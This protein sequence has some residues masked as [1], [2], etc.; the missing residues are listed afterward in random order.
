MKSGIES[1]TS[2]DCSAAATFA[3]PANHPFNMPRG[4]RT[5]DVGSFVVSNC[6]RDGITPFS[7]LSPSP[8]DSR[9]PRLTSDRTVR[10]T[11]LRSEAQSQ[12]TVTPC[13][14]VFDHRL[15][16]R[17]RVSR[18]RPSHFPGIIVL[19]AI[20]SVRACP[21]MCWPRLSLRCAWRCG[22]PVL[23]TALPAASGEARS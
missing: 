20:F 12:Y 22:I 2:D 6:D 8:E 17:G 15:T 18:H 10:R 21:F 19:P 4:I 9:A 3:R 7:F 16:Y 1:P 23:R 11:P 14:V 5:R 13:A